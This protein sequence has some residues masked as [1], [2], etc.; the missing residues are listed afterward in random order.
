MLKT[1]EEM[2]QA[3]GKVR[4]SCHST[5]KKNPYI[6]DKNSKAHFCMHTFPVRHAGVWGY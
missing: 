3:M 4:A 6:S 5:N 2:G 1:N